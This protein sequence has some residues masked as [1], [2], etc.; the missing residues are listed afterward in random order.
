MQAQ[1]TLSPPELLIFPLHEEDITGISF[2]LLTVIR[3]LCNL[4]KGCLENPPK[5]PIFVLYV[6][7]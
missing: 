6:L 3:K 7:F 4:M 5:E 2:T 1:S